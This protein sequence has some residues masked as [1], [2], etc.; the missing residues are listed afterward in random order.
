MNPNEKYVILDRDGTIL[1]EPP[2][3]QVDC[4]EKF[5]FM[6]GVIEALIE[7]KAE[8]YK[9]ILITNQ[10]GLGTPSYPVEAYRQVNEL[11]LGILRSCGI[12][13]ETICVCPHFASENCG[14]RKPEP[15]LLPPFIK[16]GVFDKAN[17]F[18]VGDRDCDLELAQKL[19]IRGLSC[20]KVDWPE[21]MK[22]RDQPQS[23]SLERVTSET[24]VKVRVVNVTAPNSIRTTL[25]FF[26]HMLD[27]LFR[28]SGL[29][30]SIEA[31]GDIE[32]GDHHLIEDV[33][34]SLGVVLAD[35]AK[36]KRGI[37]RFSQW[38]PMDE[39][40]SKISLDLSGRPSFEFVGAFPRE[41]I[42][43]IYTEMLVHFFKTLAFEMKIAVHVELCG[44]NTH[45]Q[46]EA[47]FKGFGLALRRAL[48]F[49]ER[50]LVPSTKGV[51]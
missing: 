44:L 50:G 32:V 46:C 10:D 26:D 48:R 17:S 6:A 47:L 23:W 34:I 43:G 19:G 1:V 21:L 4:V 22:T 51:L 30:V 15:L 49:T 3:K 2:D 28:F 35:S 8:G 12:F 25:P 31:T 18:V 14:C 37:K 33:A 29:S 41:T 5:S 9:F 24:K 36:D 11:M 42:G 45:H 38:T 13:F 39:S 40:L 20:A 7:L 27:A 16:E